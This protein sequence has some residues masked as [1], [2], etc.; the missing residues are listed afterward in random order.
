M[1][2]FVQMSTHENFSPI[3]L[4]LLTQVQLLSSVSFTSYGSVAGPSVHSKGAVGMQSP[5]PQQIEISKHT[6]FA[7]TV[8]SNVLLDLP[9][10][11]NQ[12]LK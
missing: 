3:H 9:F 2:P 6:D 4:L 1:I 8:L 12:S 10:S 5:P 11:R 7:D